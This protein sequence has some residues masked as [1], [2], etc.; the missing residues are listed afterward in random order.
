[1]KKTPEQVKQGVLKAQARMDVV[2]PPE[3]L[4]GG[5]QLANA[6]YWPVRALSGQDFLPAIEN[7]VASGLNQSL[8]ASA[9]LQGLPQYPEDQL[10]YQGGRPIMPIEAAHDPSVAP[11]DR[12]L[13]KFIEGLTTPANVAL[14]PL[15]GMQNAAGKVVASTFVPPMVQG[16]VEQGQ[17]ALN[18]AL[19]T[20]DRQEA[21]VSALL[22]GLMT[23]GLGKQMVPA[24]VR[25]S[26]LQ[27]G[28]VT[29]GRNPVYDRPGG[30]DL[31][32]P[33]RQLPLIS[34][35]TFKENVNPQPKV[36]VTVD[37]RTK[38]LSRETKPI[39][40]PEKMGQP[41]PGQKLLP[42]VSKSSVEQLQNPVPVDRTFEGTP[43]KAPD[44]LT[45]QEQRGAEYLGPG[46]LDL[47]T[48]S[49]EQQQKINEIVRMQRVRPAQESPVILGGEKQAEVKPVFQNETAPQAPAKPEVAKLAPTSKNLNPLGDPMGTTYYGSPEDV[50]VYKAAQERL[51]KL[52]QD[53]PNMESPD[54]MSKYQEIVKENERVKNKYGGMP[55]Q[56]KEVIGSEKEKGREEVLGSGIG[57]GMTK[58]VEKNREGGSVPNPFPFIVEKFKKKE[59]EKRGDT[60]AL[61]GPRIALDPKESGFKDVTKKVDAQQ[62]WN[63]VKNK[64]TP[65]EKDIYEKNGVDKKIVEMGKVSPEEAAEM[66]Q[67]GGVEVQTHSYGM[68]G[69]V[70]EAKK[71]MNDLIHQMES[72]SSATVKRLANSDLI[73]LRSAIGRLDM[74]NDDGSYVHYRDMTEEGASM[75]KRLERLR[76]K[77]K[78]EPTSEGP[79]ATSAYDTVSAFSTKEPMP[80]WTA[81]KSRKNVQRV[82]VVIPL[83]KETLPVSQ[84][85]PRENS[86]KYRDDTGYLWKEDNLH[87]NLSNTL[88]WAMIQYKDGPKGEK[89]AVVVE[90]QSRWGQENRKAHQN[91]DAGVLYAGT[92]RAP[93]HPL[94]KD[95][96]RL[97]LKAAIDQARKEGATHIVVSDAESAMMTEGHDIA[98]NIPVRR[99]AGVDINQRYPHLSPAVLKQV[100]GADYKQ[101][102][103]LSNEGKVYRIDKPENNASENVNK[104]RELAIQDAD[105]SNFIS[106]NSGMRLN[107]DTILPKIM[108]ELS[109][110]KGERVSM[111]EHKNTIA[112]GMTERTDPGQPNRYRENLIFRNPDGTPKTDVSGTMYKIP[113]TE[114]K[115]SLFE[116]DRPE[117]VEGRLYMNPVGPVVKQAVKDVK[118]LSKATKEA[119]TNLKEYF[120]GAKDFEITGAEFKPN[121]MMPDYQP[122]EVANQIASQPF[123]TEKIPVLGRLMGGK[124]RIRTPQDASVA[125]WY[126]ERHG[127][128]PAIASNVGEQIRGRISKEF[129]VSE[130]GDLNVKALKLGLSLKASDVFERLQ[131]DPLAYDLTPAQRKVFKGVIEPIGKRTTFLANKY[132]IIDEVID[133]SGDLRPH[134]PR[135]VTKHPKIE[136]KK[137]TSAFKSRAFKNES[138]GWAKGYEYERD[139]EKRIVTN[140]E[141]LYRAIANKR[142][143]TD[144]VLGAKTEAQVKAE[145]KESYAEQLAT[146]EI[147]QKKIDRMAE[148]I[149]TKGQVMQPILI[150][151][152]FDEKTAKM[153][154]KEFAAEQSKLRK[155]ITDANS[156]LKASQLGFDLGVSQIQLLPLLY[157][158][159]KVWGIAVKDSVQGMLNPEFFSNYVRQN[160][161]AVNV[162]AQLGSPVGRLQ[163]HMSGLGGESWLG[164]TPLVGQAAKAFGRQFQTAMDVAKVELW[165]AQSEGVPQSEWPRLARSVES[166]L[167]SGRSESAMVPHGR[168]LNERVALLASSYYRG[169]V[170]HVFALGQKGVSGQKLRN[171]MGR[172]ILGASVT[173]YAVAKSLGMSDEEIKEGFNPGNTSF[174]TWKVKQDDGSVI[175]LGFGGIFRSF[176]KLGASVATTPLE[177]YRNFNSENNPLARWYRGHAGPVPGMAWDAVS[178]EDFLGNK[179]SVKSIA[180]GRLPLLAQEA[181]RRPEEPQAKPLDYGASA[182]GLSTTPEKFGARLSREQNSVALRMFGKEF[183]D[184]DFSQ[185]SEVEEDV[186][187]VMKNVPKGRRGSGQGNLR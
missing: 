123:G 121:S 80:E 156:L 81:T 50:G 15:G 127:V 109:G 141:R 96:N 186:K 110:E 157:N 38:V 59:K 64:L 132:G 16:T 149:R 142:L 116:K 139:L 137:A 87:E 54:F 118:Q 35:S 56:F 18:P 179:T 53:D 170:E 8:Q 99:F 74:R 124:A 126:W 148:G 158:N 122:R 46:T 32:G 165:K 176:L 135:I 24:Q 102:Q 75:I 140:T 13:L 2:N 103:F 67:E 55:P 184:L 57:G 146:G 181:M 3:V 134:F 120:K 150:R 125:A 14:L 47:S 98:A 101:G 10:P 138:E 108:E 7:T 168:A 154:N 72:S 153:L 147:T 91:M 20:G 23:L 42:M 128:G 71:E 159:P 117:Q 6:A 76:F 1:M 78:N 164:R 28:D 77:V 30:G 185:R 31:I 90:A 85:S 106:Q 29:D 177:G 63:R 175:N 155:T 37:P 73:D 89:V 161:E 40:L 119:A 131:T 182:L 22:S 107:Y 160:K 130:N 144:P 52:R 4:S 21:A 79:R 92:G 62:L 183:A 60:F 45:P 115:F 17:A 84:R 151:S 65:A 94:L 104:A 105:H 43:I 58:A 69:K 187:K 51:V 114:K 167:L 12:A 169:A 166:Q 26:G 173:Y 70:S 44:Y 61:S 25:P 97:I 145:I 100:Y 41:V 49:P 36:Q 11:V 162:L 163:E 82:D 34:E 172:F 83:P 95:Y 86:A 93:D 113:Q 19:P 27:P 129:K 174:M 171:S 88:G 136:D 5:E 39:Q 9:R 112:M 133:E 180:K 33:A 48:L 111:G 68:E 178:G 152:I 143:A 66:L